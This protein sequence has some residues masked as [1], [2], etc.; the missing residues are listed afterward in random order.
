MSERHPLEGHHL[1]Y[2]VMTGDIVLHSELVP[3]R[4]PLDFPSFEVPGYVR[5]VEVSV[6]LYGLEGE[7]ISM[8]RKPLHPMTV[9]AALNTFSWKL[10]EDYLVTV[11]GVPPTNPA[12]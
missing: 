1:V 4:T 2:Q 9:R 7:H 12:V 3:A 10:L 5:M 8:I 11:V 6:T